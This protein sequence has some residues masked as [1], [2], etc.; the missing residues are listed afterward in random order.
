MDPIVYLKIGAALLV[1]IVVGYFIGSKRNHARAPTRPTV[2]PGQGLSDV[3]V[4]N[5][6]ISLSQTHRRIHADRIKRELQ[7]VIATLGFYAAGIALKFSE[8][9]LPEASIFKTAVWIGF[10]FLAVAAFI[11]LRGSK[12]AN[13]INQNA[14]HAAEG[15][16]VALLNARGGLQD[17]PTPSGQPAKLRWLWEILVI[18]FGALLSAFVMTC[19]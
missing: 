4:I 19:I 15:T 5:T 18:L 14:A 16:L 12:R 6:L 11:Y 9:G 2:Q 1:G 7:V 8:K 3:S 13:A 17:Y 10:G